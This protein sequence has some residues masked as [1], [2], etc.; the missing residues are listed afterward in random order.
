MSYHENP[1]GKRATAPIGKRSKQVSVLL[2]G[3]P[4]DGDV[5]NYGQ[6]L[7][8]TLVLSSDL[9]YVDYYRKPGTTTYISADSIPKPNH[10]EI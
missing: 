7:P 10:T 8:K 5:V 2:K 6:P 9:G 1:I 4:R 3:G